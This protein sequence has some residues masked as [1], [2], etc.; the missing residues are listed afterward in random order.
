MEKEAT[1]YHEHPSYKDTV[2]LGLQESCF[3]KL[4]EELGASQLQITP[5]VFLCPV[6]SQQE[7]PYHAPS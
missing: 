5:V 6:K 2:L 7:S 1:E 3:F 4:Q